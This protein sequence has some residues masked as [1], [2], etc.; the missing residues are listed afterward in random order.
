MADYHGT[1]LKRLTQ[2]S[3]AQDHRVRGQGSV[4]H[5]AITTLSLGQLL[6]TPDD[7][8]ES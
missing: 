8:G 1:S 4:S 2:V 3:V 5:A 6:T 7:G